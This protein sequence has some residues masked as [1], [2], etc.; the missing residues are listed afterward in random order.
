MKLSKNINLDNINTL[1]EFQNKDRFYLESNNI[2]I[3]QGNYFSFYRY[4][5]NYM[6]NSYCIIKK[7]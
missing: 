6:R 2:H 4:D 3:Y 5:S 1:I 7:N